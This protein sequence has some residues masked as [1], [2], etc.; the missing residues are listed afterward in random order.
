MQVVSS[1]LFVIALVLAVV[2]G[3]QTRAWSWGPAM[4]PL[5]LAALVSIPSFVRRNGPGTNGWIVAFGVL[6]AG[7]FSWRA[8]VSPVGEFAL[9]D[10]LLLASAVASFLVMRAIQG[11]TAAERVLLW[12]IALL[13]LAS[14]VVVARQAMDPSYSPLFRARAGTWPSGFFAHYNEGANFLIGSSFL[15]GAAALTGRHPLAEKAVW[16]L[17]SLAGLAA[18]YFTHSRG[19]ILAVAIGFAAF[20][21][22]ALVIGKRRGSRWFAPALVA[23]PLI[24]AALVFFLYQG[25][26]ESQEARSQTID[27]LG[28][29]TIRLTLLGI[30]AS[31]IADHPWAGGGSR[32]FSWEVLRLWETKL[33]GW[34]LARPELVHNEILQ[35]AT[36]Y[37][38]TGAGLLGG[39]LA[40]L[41]AAGII[42]ILFAGKDT[43]EMADAWRLGGI[44]GLAGMF[45]QSSF[46]FVF[47]LLP[48]TILLGLCLGRIAFSPTRTDFLKFR[49]PQWTMA[50]VSLVLACCLLPAG[51][52]ATRTTAAL[53]SVYVSKDPTT[54]AAHHAALNE[55]IDLW[56]TAEFLRERAML[57]QEI[58]SADVVD[59]PSDEAMQLALEDYTKALALNPYDATS[60]INRANLLS[61]SRQAPEA[62]MEFHRA[63]HLQGGMEPA[64]R[65]RFHF[66]WH[67]MRKGHGFLS[68]GNHPPALEAFQE[69]I[70]QLE[71]LREEWP[72]LTTPPDEMELKTSLLEGMGSASEG[73]EEFPA[74]L[75]AYTAA[76]QLPPGLRARYHGAALLSKWGTKL[77]DARRPSEA[78]ACFLEARK[79]FAA[80]T[81]LPEGVTAAQKEEYVQYVERSITFLTEAKVTPAGQLPAR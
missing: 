79:R 36:D 68:S 22:I 75:E 81:E 70:A 15:L 78:L 74:A 48:G 25:W 77:W 14:V 29:N 59:F 5:G 34:G 16:G 56:P 32:S 65:A 20:V 69:G 62:E 50:A 8:W 40:V 23:I 66:A 39:L 1:V 43:P 3:P 17:I 27:Q 6:A 67:W 24:G 46:S 31:S 2:I 42:R 51:W 35:A 55:A 60:S 21:A 61:N 37:G 7:W 49:W 41:V 80:A 30:S 73:M 63:I 52:A 9:A 10:L 38:L 54:P 13:L 28:D 53:W 44:A 57:L 26:T 33:H 71:T 18:V 76:A 64:F 19:G 47:H 72:R 45:V 4:I 58:A 12:G 11:N